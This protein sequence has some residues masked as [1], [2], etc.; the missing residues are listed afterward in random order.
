MLHQDDLLNSARHGLAEAIRCREIP[1]PPCLATDSF[2]AR[3][4]LQKAIRRGL[5]EIAL[6]A[7]STLLVLD[8]RVL[9]RRLL[10]TTLEDLGIGQADLLTRLLAAK[11]ESKWRSSVGGDWAV[12]AE[13][14]A[15]A[16]EGPRCQSANDLSNIVLNAPEL[17]SFKA[18]LF[19]AGSEDLADILCAPTSSL[20][21]RAAVTMH[22]MEPLRADI[23]P[24]PGF[25]FAA[26]NFLGP[27]IGIYQEAFR[28]TGLSLAPLSLCLLTQSQSTVPVDGGLQPLAN[29]GED[30]APVCWNGHIPTF[31]LDQYTRA[32]LAAIRR[33][34]RTSTGWK[35]FAG[36]WGIPWADQTK[37][38]GELLFRL[39]GARLTNRRDWHLGRWTFERSASLGCFMPEMAVSQASML[40]RREMPLIEELR[41][42]PLPT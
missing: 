15:Q 4:L 25:V 11:R 14:V 13:L 17:A 39:D 41:R 6:Q 18:S 42:L 31:A 1:R 28:Q 29:W 10:V 33:Y 9:W 37:A 8:A 22:A 27:I 7:A 24:D 36:F 35:A 40:I 21:H 34:C 3:S 2:I 32:G 5:P 19:E 23:R 20:T 12:V 16:C 30:F 38:V 26:L